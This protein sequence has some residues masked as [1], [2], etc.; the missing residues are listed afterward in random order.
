VNAIEG[1]KSHYSELVTALENFDSKNPLRSGSPSGPPEE[2]PQEQPHLEGESL[3]RERGRVW[4]QHPALI[5]CL[6]FSILLSL[7]S[8]GTLYRMH[9]YIPL[10]LHDT[11]GPALSMEESLRYEVASLKMKA[12]LLEAVSKLEEARG[13]LENMAQFLEEFEENVT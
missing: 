2:K 10:P 11:P 5:V 3:L 6:A 8:V 12:M 4:E 9:G 1:L 7:L 13:I